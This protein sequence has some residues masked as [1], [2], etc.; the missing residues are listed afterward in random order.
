MGESL[1][2][3]VGIVRTM[4]TAI[5]G[6]VL[7]CLLEKER[8]TP[9]VYPLTLNALV[10]ACNQT[11]SR[12][13]VLH[14]DEHEIEPIEITAVPELDAAIAAGAPATSTRYRTRLPT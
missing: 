14:L 7:G 10:A 2:R 11:T 4:L 3:R 5:E 6:R 12:E 9:D 8:T 1:P 13:P